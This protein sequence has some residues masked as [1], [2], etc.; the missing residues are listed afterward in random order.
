MTHC[1]SFA[2][3]IIRFDPKNLPYLM[4]SKL[5]HLH[6]Y[7]KS[8]HKASETDDETNNIFSPISKRNPLDF[9]AISPFHLYKIYE[10]FS[11]L[12]HHLV[13]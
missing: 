1:R 10:V 9:S 7:K 11:P 4:M 12:E 13:I 5:K 3:L 2:S 6:N 8:T